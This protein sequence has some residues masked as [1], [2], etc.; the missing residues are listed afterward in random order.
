MS[1]ESRWKRFLRDISGKNL[2]AL[3]QFI[4]E[5]LSTGDLPKDLLEDSDFVREMEKVNK[6]TRGVLDLIKEDSLRKETE[7]I[8]VK[9]GLR[10]AI[11]QNDIQLQYIPNK[12]KK[13]LFALGM[14]YEEE[15]EYEKAKRIYASIDSN[16]KKSGDYDF[17]NRYKDKEGNFKT[18]DAQA[19]YHRMLCKLKAKEKLTEEEKQLFKEMLEWDKDNGL[20]MLITGEFNPL[21]IVLSYLN[22]MD[23]GEVYEHMLRMSRIKELPTP[24]DKRTPGRE[25]GPYEGRSDELL[26]EK[27][28]KIFM[29]NFNIKKALHSPKDPWP[30]G[31][32]VFKIEGR[33][34][35][36]LEQFFKDYNEATGEYEVGDGATY[37]IHKQS[38]VAIK[39]LDVHNLSI[40]KKN[41]NLIE[42]VNHTRDGDG[43]AQGYLDRLLKKMDKLEEKARNMPEIGPETQW[44]TIEGIVELGPTEIF[45]R[46]EIIGDIEEPEK[47]PYTIEEQDD[48]TK[49][50]ISENESPLE[51]N[52][53][54]KINNEEENTGETTEDMQVEESTEESISIEEKTE[55][56]EEI[57]DENAGNEEEI[58]IV[59]ELAEE[60]RNLDFEFK[61]LQN[62]LKSI[63]EDFSSINNKIKEAIEL[64]TLATQE[65][66]FTEETVE[67]IKEQRK[68]IKNLEKEQ[69]KANKTKEKIEL[70]KKNNRERRQELHKKLTDIVLGGDE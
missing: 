19:I 44:E 50:M 37:L 29:D 9:K 15:Q 54:D 58:N 67:I 3:Y 49:D 41:S 20:E 5:K 52:M 25:S 59:E 53:V 4:S 2:D 46:I 65:E 40:A 45:E 32:F 63:N 36:L 17:T 31:F 35:L 47:E 11:E 24:P 56:A 55:D 8:I 10:Q 22:G 12:Y 70:E 61:E 16:M 60:I 57:L 43:G 14:E 34:V 21:D 69:D 1:E 66:V 13:E 28:V 38:P 33:D 18:I 23:I 51:A 26:P 39:R 30:T 62:N 48:E 7:E 27:I 64:L 6:N 68:I 42:K